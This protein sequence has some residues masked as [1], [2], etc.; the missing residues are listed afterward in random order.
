[1]AGVYLFDGAAGN[2]IQD[3]QIGFTAAGRPLGQPPVRHPLFNAANNTVDRSAATGNKIGN[4]GIG[5]FREFTGPVTTAIDDH[6]TTKTSRKASQS[7][8]RPASAIAG[9]IRR[10]ISPRASA[11]GSAA[12]RRSGS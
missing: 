1:M 5:N 9:P 4:S 11:A 7:R 12:T 2:L 3:N 10:S 6:D 8:R